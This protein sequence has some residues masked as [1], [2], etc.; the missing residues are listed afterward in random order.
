MAERV[1]IAVLYFPALDYAVR[2]SDAYGN[3]R[4]RQLFSTSTY[5]SAIDSS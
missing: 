1:V 4:H 3:D 5:R 2:G